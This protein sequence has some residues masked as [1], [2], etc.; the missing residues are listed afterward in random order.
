MITTVERR[1]ELIAKYLK[2]KDQNKILTIP[3]V[4]DG[5]I[6]C[7]CNMISDFGKPSNINRFN[8]QEN[9]PG[10]YRIVY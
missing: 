4:M 3:N 7:K 10:D 2:N 5:I 6:V 9:K 1:G 8:K